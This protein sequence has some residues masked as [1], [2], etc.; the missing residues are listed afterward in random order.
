MLVAPVIRKMA[1][2]GGREDRGQNHA[3]PGN[4]KLSSNG[5]NPISENKNI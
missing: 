5:D 3:F 2:I 4:Y 1:V